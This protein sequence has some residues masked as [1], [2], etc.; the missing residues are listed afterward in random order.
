[1]K[2]GGIILTQ[3]RWNKP[4][5]WIFNIGLFSW[6]AIFLLIGK[7]YG[8]IPIDWS[9]IFRAAKIVHVR[10][11]L[12][13]SPLPFGGFF[14]S[15]TAPEVKIEF[16][17]PHQVL[18]LSR[19]SYLDPTFEVS[20]AEVEAM[21]RYAEKIEGDPVARK[22]DFLQLFACCVWM[23]CWIIYPPCWGREIKPWFNLPGGREFCSSGVTAILRD[24]YLC[25]LPVKIRYFPIYSTSMV[26]PCLFDID[27]NWRKE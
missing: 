23:V 17:Q 25:N 10:L 18:P 8:K 19:F 21:N 9:M 12:K 22:Y 20:E 27:K 11:C 15:F 1:M 26:P 24:L 7:I 3:M 16:W 4:L 5:Y 2:P 13:G 6:Q 14:I